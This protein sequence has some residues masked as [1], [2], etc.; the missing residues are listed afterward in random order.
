MPNKLKENKILKNVMSEIDTGHVKM[1]PKGYFILGSVI[2]FLGLIFALVTG[3]FFVSIIMF[4]LRLHG[5]MA[6]FRLNL[7][8]ESF[9]WWALI[10]SILSI[11]EGIMLLKSYDFSYKKNFWKIIG[12]AIF[13]ILIASYLIDYFGLDNVWLKQ[14]PLRS[15]YQNQT[16]KVCQYNPNCRRTQNFNRKIQNTQKGPM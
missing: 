12:V 8:L 3:V 9:P 15:F 14:G 11:T 2:M 5:P 1:K 4:F 10:I 13:A 16:N 6:Q 7:M